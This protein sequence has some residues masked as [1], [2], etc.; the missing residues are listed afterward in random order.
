MEKKPDWQKPS[1]TYLCDQGG[2]RVLPRAS[3]QRHIN[4]HRDLNQRCHRPVEAYMWVRSSKATSKLKPA[5][6]L[7]TLDICD[8]SS[9]AFLLS[10]FHHFFSRNQVHLCCWL[11]CLL[12]PFLID[13]KIYDLVMLRKLINYEISKK[14]T[15][16][17]NILI[18][19]IENETPWI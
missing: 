18:R 7:C 19:E 8:W 4:M 1:K 14:T 12:K 3:Q 10:F 9:F 15:F 5:P 6:P 16:V 2:G 13:A 17:L 11:I